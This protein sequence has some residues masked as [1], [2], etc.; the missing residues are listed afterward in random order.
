MIDALPQTPQTGLRCAL[1]GPGDAARLQDFYEANPAYFLLVSGRP[2]N[3]GDALE[4]ILALPPSDWPLGG[5]YFLAC[6]KPDGAI[7][8]VADILADLLAPGVWHIGLFIVATERHGS[9][10]AQQW[11][12]SL[13]DWALRN[14]GRYVR[15]GVVGS[16][17]RALRFWQKSG[18]VQVKVRAGEVLGGVVHHLL[19]MV[20]PLAPA[21]MANYAELVPRDGP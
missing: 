9:G 1:L 11:L 16:N 5:K 2:A 20:K 4:D 8:A 21:T 14:G 19:V 15:L 10:L 12:A 18:F 13:E 17:A 3:A 7:V 6:A